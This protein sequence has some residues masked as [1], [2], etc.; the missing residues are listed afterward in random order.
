MNLQKVAWGGR[1]LLAP[2]AIV[3]H[4]GGMGCSRLARALGAGARAGVAIALLAAAGPAAG[5]VVYDERGGNDL[6]DDRFHPTLVTFQ[7]GV[8]TLIGIMT[9]LSDIGV[10]DR[11]YYRFNIPTGYVLE[12][13]VLDAYV[14]FDIAAFIGIQPGVVFPND[15]DTVQPGD[16]MGYHL[17]GPSDAGQD[18]LPLMGANGMGFA[19]PLGAGD[20]CIWGQQLGTFTEYTL[21][22]S[23]AEVPGPGVAVAL[24]AGL[25]VGR[26]RR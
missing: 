21:Q 20:Y 26:R 15:P 7:P 16:L 10:P 8:N 12:S 18:I 11:D 1:D 25:L 19:T 24:V 2:N 13:V 4:T 9:G 6:S 17:F 22:F 14:S 3:V 5:D 23:L